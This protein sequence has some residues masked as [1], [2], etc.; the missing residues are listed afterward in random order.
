VALSEN[1][2]F[3]YLGLGVLSCLGNLLGLC[4]EAGNVEVFWGLISWF[5][6]A[7]A[8]L[9]AADKVDIV[10]SRPTASP[11]GCGADPG[12]PAGSPSWSPWTSGTVETS[13]LRKSNLFSDL[14]H[15]FLKSEKKI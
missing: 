6:E 7:V 15:I 4:A 10:R 1:L 9:L 3:I 5:V 11:G 2:N 13:S 12:A 8:E 14:I